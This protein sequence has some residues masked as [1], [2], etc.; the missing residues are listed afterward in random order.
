MVME[1]SKPRDP[2]LELRE[3]NQKLIELLKQNRRPSKTLDSDPKTVS[4]KPLSTKPVSAKVSNSKT[5]LSKLRDTKEL[6]SNPLHSEP[7]PVL[8]TTAPII[9]NRRNGCSNGLD[10]SQPVGSSH[11]ARQKLAGVKPDSS[12]PRD[13]F[14]KYSSYK[15]TDSVRC[16]GSR[17]SVRKPIVQGIEIDNSDFLPTRRGIKTEESFRETT[18]E[19]YDEMITKEYT[20]TENE[21]FAE[22]RSYDSDL[23][24]DIQKVR[25]LLEEER[26]SI[27]KSSTP[28]E[29]P[30]SESPNLT[31]QGTPKSILRRRKLID[32]NIQVRSKYPHTPISHVTPKQGGVAGLNYSYSEVDDEDLANRLDESLHTGLNGSYTEEVED[33]KKEPEPA[34]PN[35]TPDDSKVT[36]PKPRPQSKSA[37]ELTSKGTPKPSQ[38]PTM[39][40]TKPVKQ[41]TK[42]L[43]SNKVFTKVRKEHEKQ[44]NK[45]DA[46]INKTRMK[47]SGNDRKNASV[48]RD[49]AQRPKAV[50]FDLEAPE[51]EDQSVY[52][53]TMNSQSLNNTQVS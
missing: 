20:D 36:E 28:V 4:N 29:T 50:L 21:R 9:K 19:R 33:Q 52:S 3:Y 41:P 32:D 15:R 16:V 42:Q 12:M 18:E 23:E 22:Y 30:K 53:T 2:E 34:V 24:R 44:L 38:I 31:P 46:L 13:P 1:T 6:S 8:S 39:K 43:P 48:V 5:V 27:G 25:S 26:A 35:N 40:K 7:K 37:T 51:P 17:P 47:D 49:L 11:T 10:G 45:I 14:E